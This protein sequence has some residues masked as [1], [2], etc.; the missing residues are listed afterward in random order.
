MYYLRDIKKCGMTFPRELFHIVQKV[1]SEEYPDKNFSYFD[2]FRNYSIYKEDWTTL[3]SVRG[4]C[5]GMANN[6]VTL[7]QCVMFEMLKNRLPDDIHIDGIFGNDDSIMSVSLEECR[8][9]EMTASIVE[10]MDTEILEGLN[11][12]IHP[13]KSFWSVYPILF[14]EYGRQGF[15]NKES[16]VA[17]ALSSARLAPSIKFAKSIVNALSPLFRGARV[18]AAYLR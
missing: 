16:R 15:E 12:I 7:C 6:L 10:T 5:L 11:V 2:I 8:D 13:D 17:M 9:R 4:Y 3:D 14:E 1:L 18:R